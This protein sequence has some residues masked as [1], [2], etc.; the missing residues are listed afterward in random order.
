MFLLI[1]IS[2]KT[3]IGCASRPIDEVQAKKDGYDV[4]EIEDSEWNPSMLGSKVESYE[5]I[6]F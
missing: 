6:G 2:D 4:F 3:I 5:E 1:N